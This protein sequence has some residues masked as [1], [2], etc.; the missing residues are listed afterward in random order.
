MIWLNTADV[1]EW[2]APSTAVHEVAGSIPAE[3]MFSEN[4][5]LSKS[6]TQELVDPFLE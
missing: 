2:L 6:S 5:N 3:G 4:L 1:V